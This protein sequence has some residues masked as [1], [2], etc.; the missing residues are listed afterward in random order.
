VC[1]CV[2]IRVH[3]CMCT[4]MCVFRC[5][6]DVYRSGDKLGYSPSGVAHCLW[7]GI[8]HWSGFFFPGQAGQPGPSVV[9]CLALWCGFCGASSGPQAL[10]GKCVIN[11]ELFFFLVPAWRLY[12]FTVSTDVVRVRL[13][14][15]HPT[16][17]YFLPAH[18]YCVLDWFVCFYLS[19]Y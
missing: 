18:Y 10:W 19:V 16:P 4:W 9:T 15:I 7:E 8:S 14:K 12:I 5:S 13:H 11:P 2:C 17:S 3:M 1:V 6:C